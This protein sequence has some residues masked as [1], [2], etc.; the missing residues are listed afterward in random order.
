MFAE[1][2]ALLE[3]RGL[4]LRSGTIVEA[5]VINAASSSANTRAF[6]TG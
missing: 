4:L 6:A 5:S 1:V 3:E 2:R